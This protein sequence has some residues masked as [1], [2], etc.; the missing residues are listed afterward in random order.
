MDPSTLRPIHTSIRVFE[1]ELKVVNRRLPSTFRVILDR[2]DVPQSGV[3]QVLTFLYTTIRAQMLKAYWVPDPK[4][5]EA[6]VAKLPHPESIF[7][8][9]GDQVCKAMVM[10]EKDW[11]TYKEE[12]ISMHEGNSG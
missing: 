7:T 8:R 4:V 11:S 1:A 9:E 2:P 5:A 10:P 6:V 12:W 3:G